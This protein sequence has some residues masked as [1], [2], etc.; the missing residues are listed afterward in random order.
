MISAGNGSCFT[1]QAIGLGALIIILELGD[2]VATFNQTRVGGKL[3]KQL[4]LAAALCTAGVANAGVLT[5]EGATTPFV[6]SGESITDGKYT[7]TSYNGSGVP[8]FSGMLIDGA[9]QGDICAGAELKCPQNNTSTY[10]ASLAD[11]YIFLELNSGN[12]FRLESFDASFIGTSSVFTRGLL[13][14]QG[15]GQDGLALGGAL[16]VGLPPAVSGQ[17]NFG[18]VVLGDLF[19]TEFAFIRILGYGCNDAGQCNRT[20]NAGNFAIDNIV[21]SGD[22]PEPATLGLLGLGLLGMTALRRRKQAA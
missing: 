8:G 22:V 10:Y 7:V 20:Q 21:T 9:E 15:F 13:V 4:A 11:S 18:N 6:F 17:Y 5:F 2:F 1:R 12:S 3:F 16:Q 14:L 19:S